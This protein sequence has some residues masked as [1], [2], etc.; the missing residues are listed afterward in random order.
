MKQRWLRLA[1]A[2]GL[3]L[4]LGGCMF[5]SPES[6]YRLPKLPEEYSDLQEKLTGLLSNGLTY[7]SP[8]SGSNTQS[9]QLQDLD[10]DGVDEAAVFLRDTSP[11]AEKPLKIYIFKQNEEGSYQAA[12]TI[13][14]EG[15]A[16]QWIQ[17]EQLN[18]SVMKELVIGWQ[19][20]TSVY[21]V[22]V[23]S[24]ESSAAV[25]LLRKGYSA[26]VVRDMDQDNRKEIILLQINEDETR[27]NFMELYQAEGAAVNLV[28]TAPLS[29]EMSIGRS[30]SASLRYGYLQGGIPVLFVNG[31]Y[32]EEENM[33]ISDLF[34][35]RDGVFTNITLDP[36]TGNSV[37]TIHSY[38]M[39]VQDIN[40]DSVT[41]LP[42]REAARLPEGSED[43]MAD[44]QYVVKWYQYNLQ[45]ERTYVCTTYHNDKDGW[46][47]DLPESWDGVV[48]ITRRD[49]SYGERIITFAHWNEAVGEAENFL[50][51]YTITGD[52]RDS[53]SKI[54]NR[55]V[56]LDENDTIYAAEFFDCKWNHGLTIDALELDRFHLITTEWSASDS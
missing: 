4:A 3:L 34:A 31:P 45:G 15:S 6:L 43:A 17:Y 30:T 36:A 18:D 41:E 23:Y 16:V 8:V 56:L 49:T 50:S 53:R 11:T 19:L 26:C 40:G 42:M 44:L 12:Y 22:S 48:T 39:T 25:E 20:A 14:S 2:L 24:L 10:G 51:I 7:A 54:G 21:S 33:R 35:M 28:G 37:N 47:L 52:N 1:L 29:S 27:D 46:Y 9:I 5:Q 55:V 38:S 13:E 32:A